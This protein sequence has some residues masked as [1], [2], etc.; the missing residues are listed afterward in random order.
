MAADTRSLEGGFFLRRLLLRAP[1]LLLTMLP[2]LSLPLSLLPGLL[3]PRRRVPPPR[4]IML[5]LL[6]MIDQGGG[7]CRSG[8]ECC[9]GCLATAAA[10]A[11]TAAAAQRSAASALDDGLQK[12]GVCSRHSLVSWIAQPSVALARDRSNARLSLL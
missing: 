12:T 7:R 10:A 6:R 3:R 2:W 4:F 8:G 9:C 1:F 11:A 5:C